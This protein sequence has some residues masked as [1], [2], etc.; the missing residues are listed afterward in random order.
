MSMD[1]NGA[2][3][4]DS[5]VWIWKSRMLRWTVFWKHL[6]A[7]SRSACW[8]MSRQNREGRS[9]ATLLMASGDWNM[10]KKNRT[11]ISINWNISL[12]KLIVTL[13]TSEVSPKFARFGMFR[14][15]KKNAMMWI[16][17]PRITIGSLPIF[18][19]IRAPIS[20][21]ENPPKTSPAPMKIPDNPTNCFAL[22]P[23]VVV[24]PMLGE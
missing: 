17:K 12:V 6:Q 14:K 21:K 8:N 23:I 22:S 3:T 2:N 1:F 16:T 15:I 13:P 11:N 7:S 9:K 18:F 4:W 10:L 5:L 19:V 24:N 20:P